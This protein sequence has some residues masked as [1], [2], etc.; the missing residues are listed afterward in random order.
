MLLLFLNPLLYN[1]YNKHY[2]YNSKVVMMELL[3]YQLS[4]TD[5]YIAALIHACHTR[6]DIFSPVQQAI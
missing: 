5:L 4:Y 6:F 1:S 2:F 3:L